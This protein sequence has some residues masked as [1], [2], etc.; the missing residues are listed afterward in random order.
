MDNLNNKHSD[1]AQSQP[2][3][4]GAVSGCVAVTDAL[5][6]ALQTVWLKGWCCYGYIVEDAEGWF[7]AERN[8]VIYI[9]NGKIVS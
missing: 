1:E 5:P 6:K 3:C 4:L 7:W 2:S 9:E 8:G